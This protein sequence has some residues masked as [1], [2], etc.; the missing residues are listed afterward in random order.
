MYTYVYLDTLANIQTSF[1]RSRSV[2][3]FDLGGNLDSHEVVQ[4]CL[5]DGIPAP[6]LLACSYN[7]HQSLFYKKS[8]LQDQLITSDVFL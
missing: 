6:E 2:R 3:F 4:P 5:C 8:V 1:A 7:S